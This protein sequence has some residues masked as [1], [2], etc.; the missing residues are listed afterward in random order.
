MT[1]GHTASE[2]QAQD[3]SPTLC[4]P[5]FC[6]RFLPMQIEHPIQITIQIT[7]TKRLFCSVLV[8]TPQSVE[9]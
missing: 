5:D 9:V 4:P 1:Q 3:S 7:C 2:R 8:L 6:E